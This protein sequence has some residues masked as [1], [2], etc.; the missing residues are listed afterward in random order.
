M[1]L[2][3]TWII[4]NIKEVL[5]QAALNSVLFLDIFKCDII[6][7]KNDSEVNWNCIICSILS[8]AENNNES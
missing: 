6:F 7:F 8:K 4:K 1:K 5:H 3:K 2:G